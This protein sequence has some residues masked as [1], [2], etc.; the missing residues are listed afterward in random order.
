MVHFIT[1]T[2]ISIFKFNLCA[3]LTKIQPTTAFKIYI[4]IYP[5]LNQPGL[6]LSITYFHLG[7]ALKSP[8][9][10][11]S[12]ICNFPLCSP[13]FPYK[14]CIS[15]TNIVYLYGNTLGCIIT[16]GPTPILTTQIIKL[17]VQRQTSGK[18][19]FYAIKQ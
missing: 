15:L 9:F 7:R 14:Y 12:T 8:T 6:P 11:Y 19:K 10:P 17:R 18:E 2:S 13:T 3:I 4:Y 1:W 16:G 5:L